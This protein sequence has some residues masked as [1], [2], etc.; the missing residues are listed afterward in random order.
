VLWCFGALVRCPVFAATP[1][2]TLHG[3]PWSQVGRARAHVPDIE[4]WSQSSGSIVI[5]RRACPGLASLRP[6]NVLAL[7]CFEA[8]LSL[9]VKI[10]RPDGPFTVG[11]SSR[12]RPKKARV[13]GSWGAF[14]L[15]FSFFVSLYFC[16]P[17]PPLVVAL[18]EAVQ[19]LWH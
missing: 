12:S 18:Q 6:R 8:W 10:V 5:P 17:S 15:S 4:Q 1:P 19:S 9:R 7:A 14:D 2:S 16:P 11:F 3:A 13:G